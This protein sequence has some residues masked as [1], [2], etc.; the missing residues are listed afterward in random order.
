MK[1]AILA[2]ILAGIW[3]TVSEFIRNEF[4]FKTYWVHHFRSIGL[5]F[6]TLPL[7]GVLWMI[8]SFALSYLI[9]RLLQKF[10]IIQTIFLAWLPAFVMMWITIYN[11]QVLPIQLLAFT[12]PLS[13]VEV[14]IAVVIIKKSR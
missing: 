1:K 12:I 10:T 13:L 3:I 4:L 9:F 2:I 14:A 8:W 5:E 7:N 6:K 11:L